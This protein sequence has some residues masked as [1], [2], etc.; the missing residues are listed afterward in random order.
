M[1]EEKAVDYK[2]CVVGFAVRVDKGNNTK[3]GVEKK[4]LR[5]SLS[6]KIIEGLTFMQN[7]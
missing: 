7:N 6:C 2:K 1:V 3:G 5:D 4:I